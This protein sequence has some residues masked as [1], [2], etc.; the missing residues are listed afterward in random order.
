MSQCLI[1]PLFFLSDHSVG[2]CLLYGA[3]AVPV[4]SVC[5][6]LAQRTQIPRGI[7]VGMCFMTPTCDPTEQITCHRYVKKTISCC[8]TEG[9]TISQ[10]IV[11]LLGFEPKLAT[12]ASQ[13]R[14]SVTHISMVTL[15]F[16]VLHLMEIKAIRT[17]NKM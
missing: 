12:T 3:S 7:W 11:W 6:S 13:W 14:L 10:T 4:G 9:F 5:H 2:R 17:L 1:P 8:K 15:K 16:T